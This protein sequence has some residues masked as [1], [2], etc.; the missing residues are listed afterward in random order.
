LGGNRIKS[1]NKLI[2]DI[3]LVLKQG[4][5]EKLS[6]LSRIM[7]SIDLNQLDDKEKIYLD[8]ALEELEKIASD[9]KS[10]II[11]SIKDKENLKKFIP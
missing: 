11:K 4:D 10:N 7:G 6:E 3:F 9:L 1:L 5:F 8:N 2:D